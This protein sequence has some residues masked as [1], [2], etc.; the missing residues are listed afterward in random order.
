MSNVI[1]FNSFGFGKELETLKK[2]TEERL[3]QLICQNFNKTEFMD[4]VKRN[5]RNLKSTIYTANSRRWFPKQTSAELSSF[6]DLKYLE[7]LKLHLKQSFN[8][9]SE[10][11]TDNDSYYLIIRI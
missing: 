2:E 6:D 4:E 1:S 7:Q 9:I 3:E 8:V 5:I 10:I 11:E